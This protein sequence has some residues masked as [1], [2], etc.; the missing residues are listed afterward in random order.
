MEPTTKKW[1]NRKTKNK[2]RICSK[3]SVNTKTVQ[4]IHGVSPSCRRKGKLWWEGFAEKEG[5]KHGMKE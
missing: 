1:K 4:A 2:K 3:V 5:F